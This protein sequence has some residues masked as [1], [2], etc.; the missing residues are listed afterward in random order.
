V[1]IKIQIKEKTLAKLNKLKSEKKLNS[2]DE[3]I[4]ALIQNEL[5]I[6]K[7]LLGFMKQKTPSF[8]RDTED[9]DHEIQGNQSMNI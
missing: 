3:V 7:N 5:N 9:K 6:S 8:T 2:Y 4:E 1:S